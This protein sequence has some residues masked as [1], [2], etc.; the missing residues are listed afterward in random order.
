MSPFK[1]KAGA[2]YNPNYH[3]PR[4]IAANNS[5]MYNPAGVKTSFGLH[6]YNKILGEQINK[7]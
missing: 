3:D 6:H 5:N 7:K 2:L 1:K 4:S